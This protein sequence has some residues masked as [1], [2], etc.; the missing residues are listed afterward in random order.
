[1]KLHLE[2]CSEILQLSHLQYSYRR[3][4]KIS[5]LETLQYHNDY[6]L[7]GISSSR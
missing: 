3:N 7:D 2:R 6:Y 4:K 1:M 5:N